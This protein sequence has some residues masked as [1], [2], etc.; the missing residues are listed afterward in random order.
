[1]IT[2]F[3]IKGFKSVKDV[4]LDC[5]RINIFI[6][7]PN[8]GK[9]NILEALGFLSWCGHGGDLHDY[10]RFETVQNLFCDGIVDPGCWALKCAGKVDIEVA[11][12]YNNNRYEF[13]KLG[14]KPFVYIDHN[15]N[16]QGG[17]W[18]KDLG[19]FR[20]YRIKSFE[21]MDAQDLGGLIP[22]DGRNLVAQVYSSKELRQL[23]AEYYS[24]SGWLFV[25]KPHERKFE[26]QKQLDGVA[27]GIPF[28]LT[29]DTLQRM[30]FYGVAI[31]SNKEST[32][33]FEEPE[34]HAFPY[35]TKHLGERIALDENKNQ[36]FIA[37][38]N[39]YLLTAIWEKSTAGDVAVFATYYRDYETRVK[40]L[41][42]ED[43]AW[44]FE[45]DPF[46]GVSHLTEEAP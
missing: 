28:H 35:Y 11:A 5:K 31:E 26:I 3:D 38:H 16:V 25:I 1:M 18:Q 22:P 21:K 9:S 42:P 30:V 23:V 20:F 44:L 37:T 27:V 8:T 17:N 2:T 15:G 33:V 45:A 7:E 34:A 19:F 29:S 10:V 13:S 39:P 40:P 41:T 46:L 32:L 6:G 43:M 14:Q 4:H 12:A 24:P 36:Y